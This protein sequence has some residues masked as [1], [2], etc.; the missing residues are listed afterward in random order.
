MQFRVAAPV[1]FLAFAVAS[2][3]Q[4]PNWV[5]RF[6]YTAVEV[7][8]DV[9]A[10]THYEYQRAMIPYDSVSMLVSVQYAVFNR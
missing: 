6:D 3:A 8:T 5:R 1:N 9:S 10:S 7:K 4:F 2:C